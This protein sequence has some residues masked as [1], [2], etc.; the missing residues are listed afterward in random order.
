MSM[1]LHKEL[2]SRLNFNTAHYTA[3]NMATT[4]TSAKPLNADYPH[5]TV[6]QKSLTGS[7]G[8]IAYS[9]EAQHGATNLT[10]EYLLVWYSQRYIYALLQ[11]LCYT[12]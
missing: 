7:T 6:P 2:V 8:N 11:S 1:K 12:H 3:K 5:S 9:V 4:S 10:E